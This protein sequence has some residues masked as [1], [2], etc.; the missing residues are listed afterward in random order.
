MECN[1]TALCLQYLTFECFHAGVSA[2]RLRELA[3]SGYFAFQDYAVAKWFHHLQGMLNGGHDLLARAR[4]DSESQDA[5]NEIDE[6]LDEF[7]YHYQMNIAQESTGM[8]CKETCEAFASQQFHTN[9]QCVW[10]HVIQHQNKGFVARNDISI[11][12]LR[13][14]LT[15]NRALLEELMTPNAHLPPGRDGELETFY[16]NQVHKCPKLTCFYFHE[17]FKDAKSRKEHVNRHDRPFHCAISNCSLI[18]FGFTNNKDLEKHMRSFHP[19][20]A[21]QANAFST[22]DKVVAKTPWVCERCGKRF[23]RG[24]HHRSHMRSH[25]GDRPYACPECGRAFTRAND[26]KR[27]EKI[28][29]RRR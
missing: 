12:A 29:A 6:A 13:E 10:N 3:L 7:C 28:H 15:R 23:T 5:L 2:E 20:V 1:L 27:H 26:C 14:S 9:L 25:N 22:P 21:E 17:G 18:D 11:E 4:Q 8:G 16:G 19:D 24:F